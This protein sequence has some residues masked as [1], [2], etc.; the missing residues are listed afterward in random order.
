[1]SKKES[2][3]TKT[4]QDEQAR[5]LALLKTVLPKA[6]H[7]A[8]LAGKIYEAIEAEL[9]TKNRVASFQKFC[10]RLPLPDLESKTVDEVK[11]QLAAA[12][13]EGDV[14]IQPNKKDKSLAVEVSLP[15]GTQFNT[16]IKVRATPPEESEEQEVVLKF[17]PFPVSLPGDPELTWLLAKRENMSPDE[18]GI[19]LA[20]AEEE[21]WA[22]KPGQKMLR[23]RVEKSFP[24]F[25]SRA[26]A[27]LLTELGLKRH[28]KM[29]EPIRVHRAFVPQKSGKA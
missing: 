1:M 11:L 12:F 5:L 29:P 7:D 8:E 27:G 6:T 4:K 17:A 9:R 14:T 26:P 20:K 21:F 25:I 22:S 24:E 13:G 15:D 19:A 18:A 16:E 10:D 23:D 2:K 28:Y 3:S